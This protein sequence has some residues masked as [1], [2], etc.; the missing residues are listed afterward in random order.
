VSAVKVWLANLISQRLISELSHTVD[1]DLD[2]IESSTARLCQY[3]LM[4]DESIEYVGGVFWRDVFSHTS[5]SL[6]NSFAITDGPSSLPM[7]NMWR[8]DSATHLDSATEVLTSGTFQCDAD[9]MLARAQ[10]VPFG[11]RMDEFIHL[12]DFPS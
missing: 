5:R 11:H 10:G 8:E 4:H 1:F 3:T 6:G 9:E 2:Q 12:D 7:S